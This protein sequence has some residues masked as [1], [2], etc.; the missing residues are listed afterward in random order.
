MLLKI[1]TSAF[2]SDVGLINID[3]ILLSKAPNPPGK[4]YKNG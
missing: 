4:G 1:K 3:P 2:E